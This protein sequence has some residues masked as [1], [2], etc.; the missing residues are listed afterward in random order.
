MTYRQHLV[1]LIENKHLHRV[2]LEVSSLNHVLNAS[3]SADDDLRAIGKSLLVIADR[4]ASDTGVTL[5]V[6]EVTDGD[7][8]L[9]DLL[10]QLTSRG[11]DQG[12]ALLDVWVDLL[13]DRDRESGRLSG[14]RLGLSNDIVA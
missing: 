14:S 3:R 12:L 1:S 9:L 8:D 2:G 5:D 13:Q 6:H 4:S 10:R 11:Q 7:D